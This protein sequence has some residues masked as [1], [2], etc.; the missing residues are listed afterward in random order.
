[1]R[2]CCC[3]Q[4]GHNDLTAPGRFSTSCTARHRTT[5]WTRYTDVAVLTEETDVLV[6]MP[7]G[8]KA[9]FYS[10]WWNYGAG[11][12]PRWET[13]HLLELRQILERGYGAGDA[14]AIAGESMGGLGALSYPGRH[15]GMFR[16]AASFSGVVHTRSSTTSS[17]VY[18]AVV[19][20]QGKDPIALWGDPALHAEIW[21]AHNPYD[22]AH[23]LL[24]IPLYVSRG[25]G[26]PGP[27]DPPGTLPD[28]REARGMEHTTAFVRRLQELGADLTADLYGPGTHTFPYFERALHRAFPLLMEAIGVHKAFGS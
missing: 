22:L 11:G 3:R 19:A 6:V 4:I 2:G 10:D 9:G 25:N 15:P 20:S 1:M 24:D 27:L 12:P 7:D 8:G 14:R 23:N 5:S 26:E 16:A 28:T 21:A 18:H 17:A 13:F